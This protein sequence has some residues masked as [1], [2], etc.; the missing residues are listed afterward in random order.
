[1]PSKNRPGGGKPWR[2]AVKRSGKVHHLGN[3]NT[4]EEAMSVEAQFSKVNP[5]QPKAW[6]AHARAKSIRVREQNAYQRQLNKRLN[7]NR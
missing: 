7:A 4:M 5:P 2:A 6:P 1:M 3:Y